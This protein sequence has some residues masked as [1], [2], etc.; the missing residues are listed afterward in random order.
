MRL[1]QW[2]LFQG[3][4][5]QTLRHLFFNASLMDC[6]LSLKLLSF[7]EP[8]QDESLRGIREIK[9]FHWQ[10]DSINLTRLMLQHRLLLSYV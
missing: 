9:L 1:L 6:S 7:E 10:D 3:A 2:L 8:E 4:R 5:A